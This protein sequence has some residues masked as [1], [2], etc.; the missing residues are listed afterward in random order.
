MVGGCIR[1]PKAHAQELEVDE[2]QEEVAG[3][4]QQADDD[5]ECSPNLSGSI[6]Q[7]RRL[8]HTQREE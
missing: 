1:T 8:L 5:Q 7:Q 2:D 3:G 4:S 6:V